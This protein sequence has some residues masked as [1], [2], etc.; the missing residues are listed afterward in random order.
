MY[1]FLF[2]VLNF[3][4]TKV[5]MDKFNRCEMC[6]LSENTDIKCNC[7]KQFLDCQNIQ[8]HIGSSNI[9][10]MG[11]EPATSVPFIQS[12]ESGVHERMFKDQCDSSSFRPQMGLEPTTSVPLIYPNESTSHIVHE[13][14]FKIHTKG[15]QMELKPSTS[16][17]VPRNE[18]SSRIHE[19]VKNFKC[20]ICGKLFYTSEKL[21][22]HTKGVHERVF[23]KDQCDICNKTFSSHGYLSR[24][25]KSVHE[26]VKDYKCT[27]CGKAY[28]EA[29]S[30][31]RHIKSAH[32]T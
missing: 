30:V 27:F 26:G 31:K 10:Q 21:K 22:I 20:N 3:S 28:T 4:S 12:N 18:T 25:I 5:K 23:I 9:P 14:K 19:E 11:F 7:V 15:V 6:D 24:H 8:E 16:V 13:E 2:S 29:G 32:P 17:P 1:Y